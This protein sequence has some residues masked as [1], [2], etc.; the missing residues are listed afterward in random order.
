MI[1]PINNLRVCI[2]KKI[3]LTSFLRVCKNSAHLL[4]PKEGRG[5]SSEEKTTA[6]RNLKN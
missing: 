2:K 5:L 4:D 3:I 1:S 6:D